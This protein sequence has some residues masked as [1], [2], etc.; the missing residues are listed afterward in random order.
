MSIERLIAVSESVAGTG[1]L[2]AQAPGDTGIIYHISARP[3]AG[4]IG[5]DMGTIDPADAGHTIKDPGTFDWYGNFWD[6]GSGLSL[7]RMLFRQRVVATHQTG[8]IP[9]IYEMAFTDADDA[10]TFSILRGDVVGSVGG[11]HATGFTFED[12]SSGN[13]ILEM[14]ADGDTCTK[15]EAEAPCGYGDGRTTYHNAARYTDASSHDLC[16]T[17]AVSK[18]SM[19]CITARVGMVNEA[20]PSVARFADWEMK[21]TFLRN[22]SGDVFQIGITEYTYENDLNEPTYGCV[23]TVDA[24]TETIRVTVTG[25]SSVVAKSVVEAIPIAIP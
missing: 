13:Q 18:S 6:A 11:L 21:G 16:I 3:W 8:G 25:E 7:T 22:G 14:V 24:G 4:L 2:G 1:L 15:R 20:F 23:F 9:D 10:I 17:D 5:M 12:P 19:I